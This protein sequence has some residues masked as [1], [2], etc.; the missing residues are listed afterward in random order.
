VPAI[1]LNAHQRDLERGAPLEGVNI[2]SHFCNPS[3]IQQAAHILPGRPGPAA[4]R[5]E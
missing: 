2:I 4:C 3:G 5:A 1:F